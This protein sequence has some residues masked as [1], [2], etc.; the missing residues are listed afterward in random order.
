MKEL[1]STKEAAEELRVSV[2]TLR[3]WVKTGKAKP[4]RVGVGRAPHFFRKEEIDRLMG[5]ST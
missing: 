4:F 2:K 3:G 1:W 5:R